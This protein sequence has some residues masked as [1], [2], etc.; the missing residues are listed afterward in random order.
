[1]NIGD[2]FF[3]DQYPYHA[4]G[5]HKKR[6]FVYLGE[7]KENQDPLDEDS[8][9]MIIA[10]TTTTQLHYYDLGE[11]RAEH[12]YVRF[13]PNDGF[14][15]ISE[16]IL[17]LAEADIVV[18]KTDFQK[19]E[20]SGLIEK[21]GQLS[22]SKLREIYRKIWDSKGY[23]WKLKYQIRANLNEV[24]ITGLPKLRKPKRDRRR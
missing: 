5:K 10:P 4:E 7:F 8:P 13:C 24:G 11:P 21:K 15:F 16:C 2:V 9:I 18:H 12:L 1:M 6:W 22:T 14:G 17:D 20:K 23:S 3:W 19:Q